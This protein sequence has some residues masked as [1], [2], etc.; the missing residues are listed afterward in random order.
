MAK[1]TRREFHTLALAAGAGALLPACASGI[2][3]AVT[4]EAGQAVL[5]FTQFPKLSAVGGSAVV[6]VRGSFPIVVVRTND[7][8]AVALSATCTHQACIL[9]YAPDRM[10]IHCDCHNADFSITGA[11]LG[12]PTIIPLPVYAATVGPDAITVAIAS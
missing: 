4:P 8:T 2:D 10:D 3:G 11:V 6:D 9:R 7:A 12:G 5:S 1:L